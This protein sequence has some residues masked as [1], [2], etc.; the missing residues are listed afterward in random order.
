MNIDFPNIP[1]GARIHPRTLPAPHAVGP[2]NTAGGGG[3]WFNNTQAYELAGGVQLIE[4]ESPSRKEW[5][6]QRPP[7]KELAGGDRLLV[8]TG[9]ETSLRYAASRITSL[10]TERLN[11]TINALVRRKTFDQYPDWQLPKEYPFIKYDLGPLM[12]QASSLAHTMSADV[13]MDRGLP[14]KF[15]WELGGHQEIFEQRI[16]PGGVAVTEINDYR[17]DK[18]HYAYHLITKVRSVDKATFECLK[19]AILSMR[20]HA[21]QH[22][23]KKICMP[24]LAAGYDGLPWFQTCHFIGETFDGWGI[25]LQIHPEI[26]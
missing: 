26:E 21:L 16:P 6:K 10:E 23:V 18:T 17:D 19:S 20:K 11:C 24:M 7:E 12:D 3:A 8:L 4:C 15:K 14:N 9:D 13:F 2:A 5:M 1:P 22:G 25:V